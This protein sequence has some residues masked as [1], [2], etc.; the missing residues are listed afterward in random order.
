MNRILFVGTQ[1]SRAGLRGLLAGSAFASVG[2]A[3]MLG[4]AYG[5]LCATPGDDRRAQILLMYSEGRLDEDEEAML[6]AIHRE[7]PAVKLVI[8]GDPV[9][10]GRL[11]QACPAEID[12]YLLND[13]SAAGLMHALDL[14]V[15]GQ[16]VFPP[17]C[18]ATLG[19]RAAPEPASGA[20]ET[21]GLSAREAQILQLLIA[22]SSNKAIARDLA[23]SH[24]TVK[25]HMK[26]LLRKLHARNR[27]Q[28]AIW[29]LENVA[30]Q[31]GAPRTGGFRPADLEEPA[32]PHLRVI[33]GLVASILI[34]ASEALACGIEFAA[35]II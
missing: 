21:T 7:R 1:L 8:V 33:A 25:V 34:P 6:R 14:I 17:Y 22:G 30:R 3:R 19:A 4:E 13:M 23:I 26:A 31:A 10:L 29:G 24:E 2:E 5:L 27:T 15:A 20:K 32:L 9:S 35:P 16:R 11:S 12:G 18:H 28:A